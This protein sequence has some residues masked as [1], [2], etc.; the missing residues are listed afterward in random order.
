MLCPFLY[1]E[2]LPRTPTRFF[3]HAVSGPRLVGRAAGPA[4]IVLSCRLRLCFNKNAAK[5]SCPT[6]L[7]WNGCVVISHGVRFSFGNAAENL[8]LDR[9]FRPS[10][11]A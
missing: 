8:F 3:I 2:P 1:A 5:V 11:P 7:T 10:F 6:A 9:E 4:V